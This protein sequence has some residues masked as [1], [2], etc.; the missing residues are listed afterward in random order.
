M[1]AEVSIAK[2][3]SGSECLEALVAELRKVLARDDRFMP[4]M[5]YH[6]F[7]AVIDLKFFPHNSFLPDFERQVQVTGGEQGIEQPAVEVH[8]DMPLRPPN[9]VREE[10]DLP[11]PVLV[12]DGKGNTHEEWKRIGRKPANGMPKNKIKGV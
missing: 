3:L 4:H 12:T 2:Q 10:A 7:R 8:V 9:E 1:Q 6:G 11:T 5:A